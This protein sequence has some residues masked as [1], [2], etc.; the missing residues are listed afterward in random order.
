MNNGNQCR[1]YTSFSR[2]GAREGNSNGRIVYHRLVRLAMKLVVAQFCGAK[3]HEIT[4]EGAECERSENM[5]Q[6]LRYH[7]LDTSLPPRSQSLGWYIAGH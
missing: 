3:D 5:M 1:L 7:Q 4:N 6:F 2:C